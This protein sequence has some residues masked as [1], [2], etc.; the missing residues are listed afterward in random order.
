MCD[1]VFLAGSFSEEDKKR[2]PPLGAQKLN[3]ETL[4]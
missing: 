1:I 2:K 4:S 3:Y